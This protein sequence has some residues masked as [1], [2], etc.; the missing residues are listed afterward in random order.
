MP[1]RVP[2]I[3][4]Q[5]LLG[6]TRVTDLAINVVLPWLWIRAGQVKNDKLKKRIEQRHFAWPSTQDNSLLLRL[7]RQR[8]LGGASRKVLRGVV[9][10]L[11]SM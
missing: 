8:S 9:A 3:K 1:M 5:P 11:R 2:Q 4:T 10:R 6:G 7:A